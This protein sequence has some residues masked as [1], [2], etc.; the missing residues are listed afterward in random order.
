MIALVVVSTCQ[1]LVTRL[2]TF[3]SCG[4]RVHTMPDALAT[5]TAATRSTTRSWSSSSISCGS[6]IAEPVSS[7]DF[8][9][10]GQLPGLPGGLGRKPKV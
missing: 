8:P 9:R 4:T 7:L 5:S 2:P 3:D 10:H 1:T 6:R